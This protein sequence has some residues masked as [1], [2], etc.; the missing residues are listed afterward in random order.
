M[1]QSPIRTIWW[2]HPA[3]PIAG[4][5]G[6]AAVAAYFLPAS[7]YEQQW[8]TWKYF[9][10]YYFGVI[11]LTIACFVLGSIIASLAGKG[12][13]KPSGIQQIA[14]G[15]ARISFWISFALCLIGYA[16]WLAAAVSR[17][18]TLGAVLAVLTGERGAVYEMKEIYLVTVSGVTTLTQFGLVTVLLGCIIGCGHGWRRVAMPCAIVLALAVFR[19][20][21]NSERLAVIELI[22]PFTIL[23]LQML[24]ARLMTRMRGI[25]SLAPIWAPVLLILGFTASESLRSWSNFYAE[26]ETSLFSFATTRLAGYYI[27]A[28][29]NSAIPRR[30]AFAKEFMVER[31]KIR[32]VA[33]HRR[34]P[35]QRLQRVSATD[36]TE[37][38]TRRGYRRAE[39]MHEPIGGPRQ[40]VFSNQWSVFSRSASIDVRERRP[41]ECPRA[42]TTD[43]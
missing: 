18:M 9:S 29:N 34:H 28:I 6:A 24:P 13:T 38:P 23:L 19:A 8:R 33:V 21:L 10:G 41:A 17:G 16:A 27:T 14:I 30:T 36:R 37:R 3:T 4:V 39:P 31:R 32:D 20:V 22:V 5:A 12:T 26:R 11:A 43:H 7:V 25:L 1:T 40:Q 2:I 42:P 15:P 35:P